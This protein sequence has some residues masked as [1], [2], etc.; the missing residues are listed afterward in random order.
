MGLDTGK[1][2]KYVKCVNNS[3][4]YPSD[5][6]TPSLEV[7]KEYFVF[8]ESDWA[9]HIFTEYVDKGFFRDDITVTGNVIRFYKNKGKFVVSDIIDCDTLE[10]RGGIWYTVIIGGKMGGYLEEFEKPEDDRIVYKG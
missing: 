6:F 5:D 9:Y 1:V 3:P 2:R 10:D 8:A 4:S 7:G